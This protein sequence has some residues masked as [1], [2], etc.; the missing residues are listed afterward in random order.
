MPRTQI[1]L[2]EDDVLFRE[3][4]GKLLETELDLMLVAQ[5]GTPAEALDFLARTPVD[6]VLM[7]AHSG[8]E[9]A[10]DLVTAARAAGYQGKF[11]LM[12]AGLN[13]QRSVRALQLG[14][15]GIFLRSR[16]LEKLL[17]AIRL[18]AGGEAWVERDMIEA[19]A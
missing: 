1:L 5:C 11:L 6:L 12:T 3:S 13:R 18:V 7:E 4:L 19:L 17:Y 9:V 15:S 10:H 2:V 14:V 16:G 8:S